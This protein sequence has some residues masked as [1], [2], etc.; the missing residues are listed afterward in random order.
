MNYC[1]YIKAFVSI[2]LK[3][4]SKMFFAASTFILKACLGLVCLRGKIN[5]VIPGEVSAA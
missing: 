1:N 5:N 2:P 3:K 4:D